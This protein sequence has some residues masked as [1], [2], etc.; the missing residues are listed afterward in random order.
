M[1]GAKVK[2]NKHYSRQGKGSTTQYKNNMK[3]IKY[4]RK[5]TFS[6]KNTQRE[7][8]ARVQHS[9]WG[10]VEW[11]VRLWS[12]KMRERMSL[13]MKCNLRLRLS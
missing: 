10:A 13:A 7:M 2:N 5:T 3:F 8:N 4:S 1:D 6:S 9:K 12:T 11:E